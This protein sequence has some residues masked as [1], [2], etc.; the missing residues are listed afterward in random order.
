MLKKLY[1]LVV[2]M[3]CASSAFAIDGFTL[4]NATNGE[5]FAVR[6][7][8]GLSTVSVA[9][10]VS[11]T[12]IAGSSHTPPSLT[13][14]DATIQTNLDFGLSTISS[15]TNGQIITLASSGV[16]LN[17]TGTANTTT[18]N[19]FAAFAAG[20][21]G[22]IVYIQ[23]AAANTDS[24]AFAES[25]VLVSGGTLTLGAEDGFV[26]I[27]AATNKLRQVSAVMNN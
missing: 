21:V 11:A 14:G 23:A 3:A 20:M 22:R 8:T 5:V 4:K 12:I 15:I 1:G 25:G 13:A 27:I 7:E 6:Y 24:I 19:S 18:T 16:E 26:A 17:N 10:T 9:G 2:A